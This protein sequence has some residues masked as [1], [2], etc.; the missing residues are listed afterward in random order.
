MEQMTTVTLTIAQQ[1][2]LFS[3]T[4][5]A[6]AVPEQFDTVI[7]TINK[8]IWTLNSN[9]IL[10]YKPGI[11]DDVMNNLPEDWD[12]NTK[13]RRVYD[14]ARFEVQILDQQI[15]LAKVQFK[16][17]IGSYNPAGEPSY[18]LTK[19]AQYKTRYAAEAASIAANRGA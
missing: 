13:I 16:S 15:S 1:Q 10:E 9:G 6:M 2:E 11:L 5:K 17:I 4:L 19:I 14:S 8:L 3:E 18:L 12:L 7:K